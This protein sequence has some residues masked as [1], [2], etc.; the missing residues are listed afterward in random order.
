[1]GAAAP[2]HTSSL[3]CEL[4]IIRARNIELKPARNLFV[5]IHLSAG[6]NKTIALTTRQISSNS[7]HLC[8]NQ[9]FSIQ[10]FGTL[11]SMAALKQGHVV[12]DLRCRNPTLPILG[13]LGGGGSRLLG[14][15][16]IPWETLFQS[17]DM[18]IEEWITMGSPG[19]A[20]P[21][22]RCQVQ[23]GSKVRVPAPER[24]RGEELRKW[25][26][27]CGCENGVGRNCLD[28]EVFPLA[29]AME[30]L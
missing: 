8:W 9:S 19:R 27:G 30:A 21:V 26:D 14:R 4:R 17:P 24:R 7:H 6:N 11:D 2:A 23:V 18:E 29:A 28:C 22:H 20:K 5:R 15:A 13:R 16:E 12:F 3:A 25:K 1:M 10:C